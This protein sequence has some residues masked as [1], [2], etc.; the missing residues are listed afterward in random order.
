MILFEAKPNLRI[1]SAQLL[2]KNNEVNDRMDAGYCGLLH[3]CLDQSG[4][5]ERTWSALLQ[6]NG[7]KTSHL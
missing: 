4:Y 2:Y 7:G 1:I 6:L 3:T 5:P